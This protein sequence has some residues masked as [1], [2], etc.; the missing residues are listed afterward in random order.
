MCWTYNLHHM[1]CCCRTRNVICLDTCTEHRLA[2]VDTVESIGDLHSGFLLDTTI[3]AVA[4]IAVAITTSQTKHIRST[5]EVLHYKVIYV[6]QTG[7]KQRRTYLETV[8][9]SV[10]YNML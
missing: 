9:H 10:R 5:V 1:L 8:S 7:R 4:I 2:S 6:K 3:S